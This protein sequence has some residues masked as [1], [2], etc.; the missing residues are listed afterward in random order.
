VSRW[1]LGTKL[2]H[3]GRRCYMWITTESRGIT[4]AVSTGERIGSA[5]ILEMTG[6]NRD[7]R[8]DDRQA[9]VM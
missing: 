1:L 3:A 5:A 6:E 2:E 9:P 7:R 4:R 8:P